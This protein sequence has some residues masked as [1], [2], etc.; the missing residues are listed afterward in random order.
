[1]AAAQAIAARLA[2]QGGCGAGGDAIAASPADPSIAAAQ[3]RQLRAIASGPL[4]VLEVF[5]GYTVEASGDEMTKLV[6][7]TYDR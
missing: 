5:I 4:H 2:T 7:M 6:S 3:V 1:M